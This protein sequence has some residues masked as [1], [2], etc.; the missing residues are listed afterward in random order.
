MFTYA[1]MS[2]SQEF[3]LARFRL[4]TWKIRRTKN[5]GEVYMYSQVVF[6]KWYPNFILKYI[7]SWSW[8]F[9]RYLCPPC[10]L[11]T[12]WQKCTRT[13]KQQLRSIQKE[14]E[15]SRYMYQFHYQQQRT[16]IVAVYIVLNVPVM[17]TERG[18]HLHN[19]MLAQSAYIPCAS[20]AAYCSVTDTDS[21]STIYQHYFW[22]V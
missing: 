17:N 16:Q 4:H 10:L 21:S 3:C 19:I 22:L 1:C 9:V 7:F 11:R 12:E 18:G 15:V 13:S 8:A 20:C 2:W 5:Q 14:W 6:N